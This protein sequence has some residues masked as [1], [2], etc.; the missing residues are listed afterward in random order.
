MDPRK[1]PTQAPVPP[2]LSDADARRAVYRLLRRER[3]LVRLDVA[4]FSSSI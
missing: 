4:A 1:V 3:L 2:P